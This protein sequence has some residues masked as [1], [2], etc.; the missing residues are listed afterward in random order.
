M[1]R[2]D[3]VLT[4][5]EHALHELTGPMLYRYGPR[6]VAS[7]LVGQAIMIM[8]TAFDDTRLCGR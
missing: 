6:N 7:L 1:E 3:A 8:F 2:R 4:E 5:A